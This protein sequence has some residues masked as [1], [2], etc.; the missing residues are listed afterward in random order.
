[1]SSIRP[2]PWLHTLPW[3]LCSLLAACS[4]CSRDPE[5]APQR[6]LPP[7]THPTPATKLLTID[8]LDV[9]YG[10]VAPYVEFYDRIYPKWTLASKVRRALDAQVLPM[11]FAQRDFPTERKAMLAQ[12]QSLCAV[13][14]NAE[15]LQQKAGDMAVRKELPMQR[16]ELSLSLF[17]FD[18]LKLGAASP[19]IEVPQ[20]Y[21]VVG[22]FD[23]KAGGIASDDF[24]DF[25][26]V[27]FYAQPDR[28]KWNEWLAATQQR[29]GARV[30]WVH[31]DFHDAMPPWVK[32]P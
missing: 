12:A 2:L 25:V 5:P 28:D 26:Q 21:N 23:I 32:L 17:L 1:M 30:T 15:E 4:G 10:E 19:P 24:V 6:G 8:G 29:C 11:R 31:P 18:R 22:A 20:G 13:A 27:P 7:E 9:T 3:I 16:L 14:G